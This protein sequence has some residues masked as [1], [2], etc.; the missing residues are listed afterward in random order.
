MFD[1]LMDYSPTSSSNDDKLQCY[2]AMDIEDV[3]DGLMWWHERC[4]MFLCLSHMAHDYL[5]IPGASLV[6]SHLHEVLN[7]GPLIT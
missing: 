7:V 4:T 1:D 5:T 3:K 6:V 2:L